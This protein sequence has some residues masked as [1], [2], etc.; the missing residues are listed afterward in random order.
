LKP[1]KTKGANIMLHVRDLRLAV[2]LT[3]VLNGITFDVESGQL[4]A[5]TGANGSGKTT[6]LRCLIGE[7]KQD[8]GTV[9]FE[10]GLRW[11]YLPQHISEEGIS[12]KD[13][14][15]SSHP[16]LYELSKKIDT[17]SD[18]FLYA[19][20][21]EMFSDRG[22]YELER[23]FLKQTSFFGF[24]EKDLEKDLKQFSEGEKRILGI[25]RLLCS[26]AHL[27][28]LDE[29]TNHLDIAHSVLL[30]E[31][32]LSKKEQ[33][34][35]F[36]LVSHDRAFIDR[37]ADKTI[38]LERGAFI[39]VD[40]GYSILLEH[41]TSDFESKKRHAEDLQ[42][43]IRKIEFDVM[44][45]KQWAQKVEN[46]KKHNS[47]ADK[48]YIGH[49][50]ARMAKRAT[51]V[52]GRLNAMVETM[53]SEKP[54]IEKP[55]RLSFPEY[56]VPS[57]PFIHAEYVV[58]AY[59]ERSLLE[60]V[61]LNFSTKD[62]I[63]IIGGN[64]E[65]KTTLMRCIIGEEPETSGSI[66]KNETVRWLYLP[67][68]IR[69]FFRSEI[70]LDN[71]MACGYEEVFVRQ[72]L[73]NIRMRREK[74]FSRIDDLSRGELMRCALV[75]A[76][77]QKAEFLFLDE[78]TNHL[79]IESLE[80]LNDLLGSFAGGFLFISHDRYF[81]AQQAKTLYLLSGGRLLEIESGNI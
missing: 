78:P 75:A 63:G 58:K 31:F 41:R 61:S 26:G 49:Q 2:D 80:V 65:G 6:L 24:S 12:A 20:A 28:F 13:Y 77:L 27:F 29:P 9:A 30:E 8:D 44:R 7:L 11:A 10:K 54:F 37:V 51:S 73:G 71:L 64:G 38:Y 32:I 36:V 4:L 74:V 3:P 19:Q 16:E 60:G 5:V 25:I 81:V 15:F 21:I 53:K 40:G 62:R 43:K 46:S 39:Q 76:L 79:D 50:S 67:Q 52:T 59:G 70:L 57:K 23:E 14:L 56:T 68:D 69:Q 48:G 22:G 45:K 42:K 17:S 47:H 34:N 1:E 72:T 33:K 18:P 55:L 35:S 66:Y